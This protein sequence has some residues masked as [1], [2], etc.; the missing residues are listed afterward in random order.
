[1]QAE[2]GRFGKELRAVAKIA[3][4]L[5]MRP[6]RS[7]FGRGVFELLGGVLRILARMG[8]CLDKETER[9]GDKERERALGFGQYRSRHREHRGHGGIADCGLRIADWVDD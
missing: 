8:R 4:F 7:I 3:V 6:R 5:G 1:M 2:G 9:G